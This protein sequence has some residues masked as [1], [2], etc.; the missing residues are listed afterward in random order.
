MRGP[1]GQ[2]SEFVWDQP[3]TMTLLEFPRVARERFGV[4]AVEIPQVQLPQRDPQ[5][6]T[7]LKQALR[8]ADVQLLNMPIDAGNISDANPEWRN[9]DLV[10]IED[11][12]QLAAELGAH[13]VRV[14]ASMPLATQPPAPLEVTIN[15]YRR[16][17]RTA[18]DLGL[19]LL[20]ENH[21]GITNDPEAVI[22]LLQEVGQDKLKLLLDTGNFEPLI[23]MQIALM[24]GR[25]A[26]SVDIT[27]VYSLIAR[28]A[29]YAYLLHAKTHEFDDMGRPLRMDTARALRIIRDA[30]YAGPISVEYEG[31]D[32]DPWENTRR[33]IELVE[34][35]FA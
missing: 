9:E 19:E 13:M 12:M 7:T 6:I 17:A 23:S 2:L 8:D 33:T 30:G 22:T 18:Q 16:L 10:S 28:L 32:G 4:K 31:S 24:Q 34:E 11:W 26:P 1:D 35:V 15:S 20:V 5:Y 27:P 29:P 25:E 14:N 21:G 3:Q